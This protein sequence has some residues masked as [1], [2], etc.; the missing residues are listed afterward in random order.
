MSKNDIKRNTSHR[1]TSKKI[2]DKE[3][4]SHASN[5][6][7]AKLQIQDEQKNA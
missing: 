6:E 2:A 3:K 4:D 7:N 1:N 5:S